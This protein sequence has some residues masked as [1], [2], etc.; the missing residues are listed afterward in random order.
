[1]SNEKATKI[2]MSAIHAINGSRSK[3]YGDPKLM[4]EKVVERWNQYARPLTPETF[5]MMMMDLKIVREMN[6]PQSDNWRDAIGY[7]ALGYQVSKE[8]KNE[9]TDQQKPYHEADFSASVSIVKTDS[10]E[11]NPAPRP[12][13]AKQ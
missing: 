11:S 5:F 9:G 10:D 1:M 12:V 4:A 6:A 2:A 13:G 8:I 3:K 7:A